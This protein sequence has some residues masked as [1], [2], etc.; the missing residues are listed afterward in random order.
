MTSPANAARPGASTCHSGNSWWSNR[1]PESG[2]PAGNA[3]QGSGPA[4]PANRAPR[5]TLGHSETS[6]ISPGPPTGLG[7]DRATAQPWVPVRSSPAPAKPVTSQPGGSGHGSHT[8]TMAR[9]SSPSSPALDGLSAGRSGCTSPCCSQCQALDQ[10][11][12]PRRL[13]SQRGQVGA[14]FVLIGGPGFSP[15]R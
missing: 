2:R 13:A 4:S 8:G 10:M 3:A 15:P 5:P 14:A 6:I 1:T 12:G 9:R 11:L 7:P